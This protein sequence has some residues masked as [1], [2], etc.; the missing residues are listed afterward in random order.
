MR[1][2][3]GYFW[4]DSADSDLLHAIWVLGRQYFAL[5]KTKRLKEVAC[6]SALGPSF[7]RPNQTAPHHRLSLA[8]SVVIVFT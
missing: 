1:W 8:V 4:T 5:F 7:H 3:Y 6:T 2:F